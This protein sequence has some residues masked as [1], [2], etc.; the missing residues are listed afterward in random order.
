MD[1]KSIINSLTPKEIIFILEKL[2]VHNYIENEK[3]IIFP[4]I[5][6]NTDI[7]AASMKLYYYKNTKTFHC[8][9]QC[10]STFNI[11]DLLVKYYEV[12]GI[13]YNWYNDVLHIIESSQP[14]LQFNFE[15]PYNSIVEKYKVNNPIIQLP[16]INNGLLQ[17]FNKNY[18]DEWL[19]EGITKEVMDKYNILYSIPQNKIII[20]HYDINNRLIGIRGRALNAS[21]IKIGKYMPVEIEG[22]WYSHP[23]SLNLYGLNQT[24]ENMDK[25][26]MAILFESEKSV[27]K[28][29]NFQTLNNSAAVCGSNF[30]KMQLNLLL[31]NTKIQEV[32]IAFDKEYC[33]SNDEKARKYFDKL[34]KICK[35]YNKYYT[36]SFIWDYNNLLNEKDSPVDRGEKIF[37]QLMK[38]RIRV[39]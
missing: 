2:G 7:D 34:Y 28:M 36:F 23:L 26:Q 39:N 9:T 16:E 20:P 6:H 10:S 38:E 37:N 8:Y 29:E 5:C 4:T 21:E 13:K 3:E 14:L 32:V 22:T 27:L 24:R 17:V 30:N 11:F 1:I 19:F 33:H 31:Y 18:C 25:T 35:K 15:Q 12:R